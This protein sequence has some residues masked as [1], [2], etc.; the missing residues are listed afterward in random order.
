DNAAVDQLHMQVGDRVIEG[1]IQEK[2][3]AR[4]T[5]DKAKAEGVKASLI[6]QQRPNLFTAR[7]AHLGPNEEVTVT[8]EYQQTLRYDNGRFHLRF[9]LAITPRYT[10]PA[11]GANA[12]AAE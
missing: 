11:A 2:A 12:E 7:V 10:P 8:I 4:A 1:R 9:P 3:A 5:Y 6:E